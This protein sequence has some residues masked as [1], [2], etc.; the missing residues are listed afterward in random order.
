MPRGRS[1]TE[2]EIDRLI[3]MRDEY[4][5]IW[6]EIARKLGRHATANGGASQCCAAYRFHKAKRANEAAMKAAGTTLPPRRAPMDTRCE[7]LTP[8]DAA[9]LDAPVERPRYFSDMDTDVMKRIH[10][11]GLTAGYFGDPPPGRSA[12]D[13]RQ[14][15]P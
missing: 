7:G 6:T 4:R 5:M 9:R 15:Q 14:R 11:Q 1:W 12:L 2:A 10:A 3:M 8:A 13:Q